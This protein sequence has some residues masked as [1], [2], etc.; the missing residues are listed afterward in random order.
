[1]KEKGRGEEGR[2]EK[3]GQEI[4]GEVSKQKKE[5]GKR[6]QNKIEIIYL[7]ACYTL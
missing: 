2:R 7:L 3:R 6:V 1:M 4:I 5:R